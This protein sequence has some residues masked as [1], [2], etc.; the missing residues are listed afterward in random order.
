MDMEFAESTKPPAASPQPPPQD[1]RSR[2]ER[3]K[4]ALSEFLKAYG[5]TAD[6]WEAQGREEHRS[7]TIQAAVLVLESLRQQSTQAAL[8]TRAALPESWYSVVEALGSE[9]GWSVQE[10]AA[11][12]YGIRWCEIL[13][14]RQ[15]DLVTLLDRPSPAIVQWTQDQNPD[16]P[17]PCQ[18]G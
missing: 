9:Q 18:C 14:S 10:A 13:L 11:V 16:G 2:V 4:Q 17:R 5:G 6:A 12:A 7:R 15:L 1:D 8:L 3:W